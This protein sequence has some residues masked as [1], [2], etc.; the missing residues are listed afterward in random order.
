M[1]HY[2]SDGGSKSNI[3]EWHSGEATYVKFFFK[4][5]DLYSVT[6]SLFENGYEDIL[7]A[8]VH[9]VSFPFPSMLH[10]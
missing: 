3:I 4:G 9:Y 2:F 5:L 6:W 10:F 8:F 1:Q 7:T